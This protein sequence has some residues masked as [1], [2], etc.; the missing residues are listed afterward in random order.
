MNDP[1][2]LCVDPMRKKLNWSDSPT[3]KRNLSTICCDMSYSMY[4]HVKIHL[5]FRQNSD[6]NSWGILEEFCYHLQNTYQRNWKTSD[7]YSGNRC[8]STSPVGILK[9]RA[10]IPTRVLIGIPLEKQRNLPTGYS[11]SKC[12]FNLLFQQSS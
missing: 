1:S 3:Q 11:K 8:F 10:E 6:Q 12:F 5:F 4:L 2:D 7:N 9:K